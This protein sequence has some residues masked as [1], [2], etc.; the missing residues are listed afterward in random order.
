LI[1]RGPIFDLPSNSSQ[2]VWPSKYFR[3]LLITY[4]G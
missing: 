3:G 2:S 1:Q 4:G